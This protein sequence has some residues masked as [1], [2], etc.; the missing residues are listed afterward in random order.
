M[1]MQ[2]K[3]SFMVSWIRNKGNMFP[4]DGTDFFCFKTKMVFS[5]NTNIQIYLFI[6]MKRSSVMTSHSTKPRSTE[7]NILLV[8]W[9]FS[10]E[11]YYLH[12]HLGTHS[13]LITF[14]LQSVSKKSKCSHNTLSMVIF[15]AVT[16]MEII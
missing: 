3:W 16:Y 11:I 2:Y 12:L 7:N 9:V 5:E 14:A 13:L 1:T 6:S 8:M 10:E 15:K 4:A